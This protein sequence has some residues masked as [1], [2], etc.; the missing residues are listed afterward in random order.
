MGA[1]RRFRRIYDGLRAAELVQQALDTQTS[2][3]FESPF[4]EEATDS[5]RFLDFY[6]ARG[7]RRVLE[8]YGIHRILENRGLGGYEIRITCDSANDHRMQV[9]LDG[10]EAEENR[11]IDLKVTLERH[12]PDGL[13]GSSVSGD[14]PLSLVIV[15]W[16]AMQDPR[17]DFA[18]GQVPMPGQTH[19]GLGIA[20]TMHNVLLLMARRLG[21]DGVVNVPERFHLAVL[22][23]RYGYLAA[24][25]TWRREVLGVDRELEAYPL[26][27]IAWAE[28]RGCLRRADGSPW[29]YSPDSVLA[30]VSDRLR[31]AV[32][33]PMKRLRRAVAKPMAAAVTLDRDAFRRS[34]ESEPVTGLDPDAV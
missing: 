7:L 28:H 31:R 29:H 10:V 2:M 3:G 23:L 27:V 17:A 19:P 1:E 18:A 6:G 22:Y 26:P 20:Y 21:R 4:A 33:G 11:V 15:K 8:A 12:L 9:L 30:P 14:T 5:R 32:D 34:L 16:L 13:E 24:N 25:E